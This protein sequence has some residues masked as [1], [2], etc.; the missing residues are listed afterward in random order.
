M[1]PLS[2]SAFLFISINNNNIF[3]NSTENNK[4]ST[5]AT[6]FEVTNAVYEAKEPSFLNLDT[7]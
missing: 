6:K 2:T 3:G 1:N 7:K 4:K 5:K